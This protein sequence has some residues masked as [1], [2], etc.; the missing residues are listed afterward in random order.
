MQIV[1]AKLNEDQIVAKAG[2]VD[3]GERHTF[4]TVHVPTA[5]MWINKGTEADRA[6][7]ERFAA[8]EGYTV[9]CY[10]GEKDP[11]AKAKKDI[12]RAGA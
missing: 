7:A 11:L 8:T 6:K 1:L 12:A 5:C 2:R 3:L 4:K 10:N 9:F